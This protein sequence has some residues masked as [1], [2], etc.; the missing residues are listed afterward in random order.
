MVP[1]NSHTVALLLLDG[2]VG[3]FTSTYTCTT[4]AVVVATIS[5]SRKFVTLVAFVRASGSWAIVVA[6]SH[7]RIQTTKRCCS[8]LR[9]PP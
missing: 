5:H 9:P 1:R 4:A 2:G 7:D 8:C 6:E 3:L